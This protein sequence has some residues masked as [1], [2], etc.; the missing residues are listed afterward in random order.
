MSEARPSQ[1]GTAV[2]D[3]FSR[4]RHRWWRDPDRI[5]PTL[6]VVVF[7][8]VWEVAGRAANPILF[9]PPTRVLAALAD[10]TASGRLPRALWITLNAFTVGFVASVVV[11]IPF[12]TVLGR[13]PRLSRVVEPYVDA[14]YATPRVVIVPLIILWF[15][16]GYTGRVFLIWLGTVIP[17]IL[18]TAVGVRNSR[19]DLIEVAKSFGIN[20]RDLVRHVILPGAVPYVIAGLKIAAGRALIGVVIA[21]IFLD[22][23]GVGGIIQMESSFFR[24]APMLAGVVVFGVLG[25]LLLSTMDKLE[26]RFS[27]WKGHGGL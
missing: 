10:L 14:I 25:T 18:N 26:R 12:G 3:G 23:T 24:V 9:A 17:I 1:T 8:A 5:L 6:A 7:L 21:E 11:G 13:L 22:L 27:A 2:P 19:P 16:V 20:E 15:G 4:A